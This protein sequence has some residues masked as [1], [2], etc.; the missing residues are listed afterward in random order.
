MMIVLANRCSTFAS[1]GAHILKRL[2]ASSLHPLQT[3]S[4]L[5]PF[6]RFPFLYPFLFSFTLAPWPSMMALA[7]PTHTLAELMP[8]SPSSNSELDRPIVVSSDPRSQLLARHREAH[9][10]GYEGLSPLSSPLS[11]EESDDDM[12]LSPIVFTRNQTYERLRLSYVEP[13]QAR[14]ASTPNSP[15]GAPNLSPISPITFSQPN[16]S[17][18]SIKFEPLPAFPSAGT[19]SLSLRLK[20]PL[21][22]LPG[23]IIDDDDDGAGHV[24]RRGPT[25]AH[26][27]SSRPSPSSSDDRDSDSVSM[28]SPAS[29]SSRSSATSIPFS[30]SSDSIGSSRAVEAFPAAETKLKVLA[31]LTIPP[32][33][34]SYPL[35][36]P[37]G[38]AGPVPVPAVA[39]HITSPYISVTPAS[40]LPP[41]RFAFDG[42]PRQRSISLTSLVLASPHASPA[43]TRALPSRRV[44]PDIDIPSRSAS[45]TP[46]L[47]PSISSTTSVSKGGMA[48]LRRITSRARLFG[49]RTLSSA[50][51]PWD[52]VDDEATVVGHDQGSGSQ[53]L[54]DRTL[55]PAS[56]SRPGTASTLGSGSG[57][58]N[59]KGFR[60]KRLE[61]AEVIRTP[62]GDVWEPR[63][64]EDVIQ[65]LRDLKL[66]SKL[67]T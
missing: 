59:E 4:H 26:S 8:Q 10:Y 61:I 45:P 16:L 13:K 35:P 52:L 33:S 55:R 48:T 37:A 5:I 9:L 42:L 7:L 29:A 66:P 14:A 22:P 19:F 53:S 32:R 38:P 27:G 15:T 49:R 30:G 51:E 31:P 3:L 34:H 56:R 25:F 47:A 63:E 23:N 62:E 64:I 21:P 11:Q 65:K 20:R 43:E 2:G 17:S 54:D 46:S 1:I 28:F 39:S 44:T 12:P 41:Q 6:P 67:R 57:S 36:A 60:E 24:P 18:S 58:G 40:P 50:S